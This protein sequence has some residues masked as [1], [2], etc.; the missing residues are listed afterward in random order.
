MTEAEHLCSPNRSSPRPLSAK[1]KVVVA[2]DGQSIKSWSAITSDPALSTS[3][4]TAP[5]AQLYMPFELRNF[6]CVVACCTRLAICTS[7]SG[8]DTATQPDTGVVCHQ[9]QH[10]GCHKGRNLAKRSKRPKERN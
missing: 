3:S 4:A 9:T 8:T 2:R 10:P 1:R 7:K 5:N 6:G